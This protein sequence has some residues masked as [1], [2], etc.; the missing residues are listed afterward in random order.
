[1][2]V[3]AAC[4]PTPPGAVACAPEPTG[5]SDVRIDAPTGGDTLVLGVPFLVE[6]AAE[7]EGHVGDVRVQLYWEREGEVADLDAPLYHRTVSTGPGRYTAR[8]LAQIDSLPGHPSADSLAESGTFYFGV[9]GET[10]MT[11]CGDLEAFSG[12]GV[13][14]PVTVLDRPPRPLGDRPRS[15]VTPL[16]SARAR[17]GRGAARAPR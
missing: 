13:A 14:A 5:R 16:G 10:G 15:A 17:P 12:G 8:F 7:A 9:F 11:P 6:I 4:E 3:L 2:G 1:M